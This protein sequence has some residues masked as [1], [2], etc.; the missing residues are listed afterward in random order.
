VGFNQLSI[1]TLALYGFG[2]LILGALI[3]GA[4]VAYLV[5]DHDA[6]VAR[7][8]TVDDAYKSVLALKYHTERLLSTPE[9]IK[10]R[11]RW[12]KS[13]SDFEHRLGDLTQAPPVEVEAL[14]AD[15]HLIRGEIDDIE[16][17]LDNP[18]FG[19][20]KLM[21]K[22]LLR[23]FGE[24]LNASASGDDYVAAVRTLVNAIDFLQQRQD[25]L[26]DD[27]YALNTRIRQE[28]EG[29]LQRTQHLLIAVALLSFLALT[30][31]AAAMFYL[32]RRS[33]QQLLGIRDNLQHPLD[34]PEF[35]GMHTAEHTR[36]SVASPAPKNILTAAPGLEVAPDLLQRGAIDGV[37]DEPITPSSLHDTVPE[38]GSGVHTPAPPPA[39]SKLPDPGR[40]KGRRILLVEDDVVNQEVALELLHD[41]GLV[42]DLAED[43]QIAL[44]MARSGSYDLILM[45]V[46]M[47]RMDGLTAS[48]EIRRLPNGGQV[49]ILAMTANAFADDRQAC[50][51]AGMNDHVAKP[52]DPQTLINALL[53]W[54]PASVCAADDSAPAAGPGTASESPPPPAAE[55]IAIEGLDVAAGLKIVSGKAAAYQRILRLFADSQ[56]NTVEQLHELL[57]QQRYPEAERIAHTLK[58]SAGNI[59]AM[60]IRQL[61]ADLEQAIKHGAGESSVDILTRLSDELPRLIEAIRAIKP[62]APASGPAGSPQSAQPAPQQIVQHLQFLLETADMAARRYFE[63]HHQALSAALGQATAEAVGLDISQF[64]YDEALARL[65]QEK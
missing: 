9:L 11:E 65:R 58:G 36:R 37:L 55:P 57:T 30:L 21:E 39:T 13:V 54:L 6:I 19:E 26:L 45:D 62:A 27:L 20:G 14:P 31:F 28:S 1:R 35:A 56:A 3:S 41:A 50:L 16:R 38:L 2:L 43:G 8:R 42:V 22:S 47:P 48:R 40:I 7:Q 32:I 4:S 61:A 15:W 52:V 53:Q 24:G 64:R 63:Q 51:A 34:E 25:F 46:Q 60:E 23:R 29:Q 49:P 44:D 59:G 33:E 5:F 10:Q 17:Q 18:L 12:E